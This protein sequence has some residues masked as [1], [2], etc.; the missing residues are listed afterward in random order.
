MTKTLTKE[1]LAAKLNG[2]SY[3]NEITPEEEQLAKE[4]HLVVIMG[5]SDDLVE[6]HGAI[7]D[8]LGMGTFYL[9]RQDVFESDC[10]E[11]EDCPYYQRRLTAALKTGE[12]LK[13]EPCWGGEGMDKH[14]YAAMAKPTWCFESKQLCVKYATFDIF[15]E[16][17]GDRE[18]FCRGIVIDLDEIWPPRSYESYVM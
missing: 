10:D 6:L 11:G 3:R 2:R 16:Y 14:A 7:H 15:D 1:Q 12:V 18:Y 8:E 4:N 5:A 9:T 13:I 17:D